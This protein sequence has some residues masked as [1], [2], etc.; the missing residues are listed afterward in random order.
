[1]FCFF[2][3]VLFVT[4]SSQIRAQQSSQLGPISPEESLG[5]LGVGGFVGPGSIAISPDGQSV[6][7]SVCDRRKRPVEVDPRYQTFTRQYVPTVFVGCSLMITDVR[8]SKVSRIIS[9]G[10]SWSPEWSSD[11]HTLAFYSDHDG[12]ARLWLWEKKSESV[13][14]V[15]N[16]IVVGLLEPEWMLNDAAILTTAL[17]DGMSIETAVNMSLGGAAN[18]KRG[19]TNNESSV[20]V[21]RHRPGVTAASTATTGFDLSQWFGDLVIFNAANGSKKIVSARIKCFGHRISPDGRFIAFSDQKGFTPNTHRPLFDLMTYSLAERRVTV[22]LRDTELS[23]PRSFSWSPDSE[24]LSYCATVPKIDC[25]VV[26]RAKGD[27]INISTSSHPPFFSG[28]RAPLWTADSQ[29]AFE[30]TRD[31]VWKLSIADRTATRVA[32]LPEYDLIDFALPIDARLVAAQNS[33]SFIVIAR[34]RTTKKVAFCSVD[35]RTNALKILMQVDQAVGGSPS[36][37]YALDVTPDGKTLVYRAQDAA[38]PTELWISDREFTQSRQLTHINSNIHQSRAGQSRLIEWLGAR[39]EKAQGIV[40][41]PSDYKE[42]QRYPVIVYQ[43]PGIPRTNHL[44]YYGLSIS[45]G[46]VDDMQLFASRGYVVFLPDTPMPRKF[47]PM[48]GILEDLQPAIDRLAELGFAD[49]NR[50]G[51]MGGSYG[52]YAVLAVITQTNQFKAAVARSSVGNLVGAYTFMG[53]TGDTRG[54]SWAETGQGGMGGTPWEYRNRY[55]ENSPFY[56]LD[57]VE[58]PLLLI[59]GS[60]DPAV[61]SI[62]SDQTFVGLRRLGKEVEYARYEGEGHNESGWGYANQLD[63]IKRVI[64]WFDEH[65]KAAQTQT[66]RQGQ[67]NPER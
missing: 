58:T 56:Y 13:R 36:P 42:G 3:C 54:I 31:G 7:F 44:N 19:N 9:T 41:L 50:M 49:T 46:G 51:I 57:H 23:E 8:T 34:N 47:S 61:P 26:A 29:H 67:T 66:D 45:G 63:Y 15:S 37:R 20:V 14:R 21:Y 62:L 18:I 4:Q 60:E 35:L 16:A 39:K 10:S 17:P 2:W 5:I 30:L 55:I 53:R 32:N 25:Y 65:L 40:L 12:A 64:S 38:H 48:A 52:G 59:H 6:V 1:L 11:G 33:E 43:Y 28:D 22:L 27:P 24:K